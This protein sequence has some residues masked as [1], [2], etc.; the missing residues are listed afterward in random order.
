MPYMKDGKR[1]Y[2]RE[3]K[4]YHAAPEQRANRSL[5]T[6][7]RNQAIS[8]GRAAKGDGKDLDHTRALSKGGSNAKSNLRLVSASSNRS[9]S[10][11]SDGSM[12][13]QTSKRES[14]RK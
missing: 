5:R 10:R 13:S 14:K 6:V 3:Y 1:D 2:K 9:F 11:N 4:E 12:K 7:A 8:D